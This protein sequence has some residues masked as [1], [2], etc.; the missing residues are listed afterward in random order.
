MDRCFKEEGLEFWGK[1]EAR[2]PI[3]KNHLSLQDL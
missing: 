2:L 1:E 3:K